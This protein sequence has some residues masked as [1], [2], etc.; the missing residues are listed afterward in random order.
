MRVVDEDRDGWRAAL[1]DLAEVRDWTRVFGPELTG[2]DSAG[3]PA[4]VTS[5]T[6]WSAEP[7]QPPFHDEQ[8]S[9]VFTTGRGVRV[10]V[11]GQQLGLDQLGG[12]AAC[13]VTNQ[14]EQDEA[15]RRSEA[16]W[17]DLQQ[18][19]V[20]QWGEPTARQQDLWSWQRRGARFELRRVAAARFGTGVNG[21]QFR[22]LVSAVAGVA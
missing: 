13:E 19:A 17:R 8:Q 1:Q 21:A 12:W 9:C 5:A 22:L 4:R 7:P 6:G 14:A 10:W 3:Y 20:R 11:D 18:L 16:P 15:V 2:P